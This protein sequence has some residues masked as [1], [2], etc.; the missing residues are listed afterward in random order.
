MIL[1]NMIL[2][3]LV[4]RMRVFIDTEIWIFSKKK[5]KS[6]KFSKESDFQNANKFHEKAIKFLKNQISQNEI[7]MT[8]HQL[9]EIFHILGF[10]GMRIPLD[11]VQRYCFQLLTSEFIIWHQNTIKHVNKALDMSLQSGIHIWDY[12]CVLPIY[13]EIDVMYSCDVHFKHESFKSLGP[14]IEN[15][16]NMWITL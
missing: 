9:C 12:L 5:P 10:R 11:N 16:L 2:K 14:K 7:F 6:E 8:Y 3:T 13:K 1:K 15:P 4:Y